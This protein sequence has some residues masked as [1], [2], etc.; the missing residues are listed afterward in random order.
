[1]ADGGGA[2]QVHIGFKV[3]VGL[4][5]L[6]EAG[7]AVNPGVVDHDIQPAKRGHGIGDDRFCAGPVGNAGAI[8]HRTPAHCDDFGHHIVRRAPLFLI[9]GAPGYGPAQIVDHHGCTVGGQ[10]Q[11]VA[12]AQAAAAACHNRDLAG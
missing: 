5:Q 8:G 7:R 4:G 11:R 3:I 1:M 12:T 6:D 2:F 10:R 9:R